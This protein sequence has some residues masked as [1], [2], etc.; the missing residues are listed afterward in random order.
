[1]DRS[2][3]NLNS[4]NQMKTDFWERVYI[5]HIQFSNLLI[6]SL[7]RE[8]EFDK[9]DVEEAWPSTPLFDSKS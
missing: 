7:T 5:A 6:I 4:L 1:M 9:E 3:L 8:K 2:I